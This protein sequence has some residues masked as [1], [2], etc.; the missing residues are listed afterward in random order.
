MYLIYGRMKNQK[1]MAPVDLKNGVFVKNLI[2][3][4]MFDSQENAQ[5]KC[6]ELN[7][8]NDDMVFEIRKN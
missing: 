1:R 3:A 4:S 7:R 8:M 2:Y 5:A 6:D